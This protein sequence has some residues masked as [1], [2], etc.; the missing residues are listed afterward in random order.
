MWRWICLAALSLTCACR[1]E[2]VETT[3]D[4]KVDA[5]VDVT[6]A[7][8]GS[9][10]SS[11]A[12]A[13]GTPD[14]DAP[15]SGDCGAVRG[16]PM[17]RVTGFC[18]D[19]TEVTRRAFNEYLADPK[20]LDHKP[21]FCGWNTTDEAPELN[22]ASLDLP[23][24]MVNFCDAATFCAWAGKRLCGSIDGGM[25]APA[26]YKDPSKSE[27]FHVCSAGGAQTYAYPGAYDA[28]RCYS[29]TITVGPVGAKAECSG[30][31]MPFS[32][33]V[34]LSGNV[35]EWES[36]CDGSAPARTTGCRVRGGAYADGTATTCGEDL[37]AAAETRLPG[38][39]FRCCKD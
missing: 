24:G 35:K 36:S 9:D 26:A 16:G 17:V 4:A 20:H 13:P 23:V 2:Q 7:E 5:D 11:E 32:Q 28:A 34:D 14:G 33:V 37:S 3:N 27:W 15:P 8:T 25:N 1:G 39:G 18:I 30:A 12:D 19:K 22:G 10:A 31:T 29:Q 38:Y 6:N 21:S